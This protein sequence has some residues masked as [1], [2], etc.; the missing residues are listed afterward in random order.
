MAE[1]YTQHGA[2]A[3]AGNAE[4]TIREDAHGHSCTPTRAHAQ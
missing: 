1:E 2:V 4:G 3:G